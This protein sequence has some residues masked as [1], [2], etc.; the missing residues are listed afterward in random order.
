MAIAIMTFTLVLYL[1]LNIFV[2]YTYFNTS[3]QSCAYYDI[4]ENWV[5]EA[6]FIAYP[7]II[8][9]LLIGPSLSV[10]YLLAEIHEPEMIVKIIG[11]Q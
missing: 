1:L 11:H 6:L 9:L 2:R 10:L 3:L 7:F 8:I 5:V 4:E